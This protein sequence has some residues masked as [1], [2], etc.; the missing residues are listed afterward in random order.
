MGGMKIEPG[1]KI[2]LFD[3]DG[4]LLNAGKG[5]VKAIIQAMEEV[6][7]VEDLLSLKGKYTFAGKTD[8]EIVR[9]LLILKGYSPESVENGF[10][11]VFDL[12]IHYLELYMTGDDSGYLHPGI[13]HLVGKL[14]AHNE[15]NTGIL[16]GNIERGAEIKLGHFNLGEYFS[17][18]VYGSDSADRNDL[19]GILLEKAR[20]ITGHPYDGSEIVIVGDSIYDIR[21]A[22]TVGARAIAV[23]TGTT[24]RE[25]LEAEGPDHIFRDLSRTDLV[26][27]AI[28]S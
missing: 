13:L 16:T 10:E 27:E 2:A 15:V 4:T 25:E 26:I 22:G 21:C 5:P 17:I 20:E 11:E 9:D 23:T 1:K 28:I 14:K 3:I 18:G 19:P 6:Y 12:Y 8:P 7:G 24:S